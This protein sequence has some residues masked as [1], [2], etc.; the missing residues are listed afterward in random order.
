MGLNI[1]ANRAD[2]C[3]S[4]HVNHSDTPRSNLFVVNVFPRDRVISASRST[5]SPRVVATL[6]SD[7]ARPSYGSKTS[8]RA[9]R[10]H[11]H[12]SGGR[13]EER[14]HPTERAPPRI[15]FFQGWLQWSHD[16][17]KKS[18]SANRNPPRPPTTGVVYLFPIAGP[19]NAPH[20][21]QE[22]RLDSTRSPCRV[23]LCRARLRSSSG[24][25]RRS[26]IPTQARNLLG[27]GVMLENTPA[28][29][30]ADQTRRN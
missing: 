14:F 12:L 17:M 21:L 26:A 15:E 23:H 19:L 29:A 1:I 22:E 5:F 2:L 13:A 9:K 25:H 4:N 7:A 27:H 11:P 20:S 16:L 24:L 8:Q 30:S 18:S 6:S 10:E 3:L 28:H